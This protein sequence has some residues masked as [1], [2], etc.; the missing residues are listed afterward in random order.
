MIA[1]DAQGNSVAGV[2]ELQ[3][4]QAEFAVEGLD[5]TGNQTYRVVTQKWEL[6][7]A[8]TLGE[9]LLDEI[10]EQYAALIQLGHEAFI[11]A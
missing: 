11:T 1:I 4:M 6:E 2:S 5:V 7:D 10:A 8:E 9:E 3:S